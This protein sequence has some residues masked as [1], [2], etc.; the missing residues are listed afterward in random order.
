M[1]NH[2]LNKLK[3]RAGCY[4]YPNICFRLLHGGASPTQAPHS[5]W[6]GG[7]VP[8]L[9]Q[10]GR[11]TGQ[12]NTDN[13]SALDERLMNTW[14]AY[15]T[16]HTHIWRQYLS[17]LTNTQHTECTY[18]HW[19]QGVALPENVLHGQKADSRKSPELSGLAWKV[20]TTIQPTK[21]H[22]PLPYPLCHC[23]ICSF[24][25]WTS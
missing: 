8:T 11:G 14:Y 16:T 17:S 20:L 19:I 1:S 24:L 4:C 18:L 12:N 10:S 13:T 22:P 5:C 2:F 9:Q 7:A 23:F 3:Q 25:L 6:W 21:T 15:N